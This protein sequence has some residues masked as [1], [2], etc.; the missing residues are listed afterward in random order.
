MGCVANSCANPSSERFREY[1]NDFKKLTV[2][3]KIVTIALS[4]LAG[5]ATF[6]LLGIGGFATFAALVNRFKRS[7]S[8]ADR[9]GPAT[10]GTTPPA[11]Q[12][13]LAGLSLDELLKKTSGMPLDTDKPVI[14]EEE[15]KVHSAIYDRVR[16][17][18]PEKLKEVLAQ[19]K[20]NPE[21]FVLL[22]SG[23][24]T[25]TR[26]IKN[27]CTFLEECEWPSQELKEKFLP[28]IL[29]DTVT[30]NGIAWDNWDAGFAETGKDSR[31]FSV[32]FECQ[33]ILVFTRRIFGPGNFTDPISPR[34]AK[35]IGD[36]IK[37]VATTHISDLKEKIEKG[38]NKDK[39][40]VGVEVEIMQFSETRFPASMIAPVL[41]YLK[42]VPGMVS[43]RLTDIGKGFGDEHAETLLEIFKSQPHLVET[44]INVNG[45]SEE[46]RQEFLNQKEQIWKARAMEKP[47]S[48]ALIALL[49]N[50]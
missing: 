34:L 20:D 5:L 31:N 41:P 14:A 48:D 46:K 30:A 24:T 16:A 45:M 21:K 6:F 17:M 1:V 44:R 13:P 28:Q 35:A 26:W 8:E 2:C 23:V 33:R 25:W 15:R 36:S 42:E 4:T 19:F 10:L 27:T 11:A 38:Q 29:R 49:G 7:Q 43:L 47:S 12:D 9:L 22:A 37:F 18:Q 3:Q 40:R 50:K 32:G 39:L